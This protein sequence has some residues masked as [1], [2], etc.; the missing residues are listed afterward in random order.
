MSSDVQL[1]SKV[2]ERA[3]TAV[4]DGMSIVDTSAAYGVDRKTVSRWVAKFRNGGSNAL[5]RKAGSGRPRKLE[6]LCESKLRYIVFAGAMSFGFETDLWTV[7]RLRRIISETFKIQLSK[8][9]VWRRLQALVSRCQIATSR[10][11]VSQLPL[12][13]WWRRVVRIKNGAYKKVDGG[14]AVVF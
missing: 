2:R 7:N 5:Q 1:S 3:T 13:T 14:D 11:E 6:D 10:S 4:L 12:P 9:R 8:N